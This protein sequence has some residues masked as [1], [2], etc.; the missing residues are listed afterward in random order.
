MPLTTLSV[1][2]ALFFSCVRCVTGE[3]AQHASQQEKFLQLGI[4]SGSGISASPL[5]RN[6]G[7]RGRAPDRI[8]LVV[9]RVREVAAF[10]FVLVSPARTS[11]DGILRS[12]P[13]PLAFSLLFSLD[14]DC[15]T[16]LVCLVRVTEMIGE[17]D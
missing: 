16:E 10:M 3:E 14:F 12:F 15:S 11:F 4:V 17:G 8:V 9:R 1:R 7:V 6:G 13:H 5:I 2:V